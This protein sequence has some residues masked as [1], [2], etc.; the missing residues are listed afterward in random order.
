MVIAPTTINS[1]GCNESRFSCDNEYE[2]NSM[3]ISLSNG[4]ESSSYEIRRFANDSV[5]VSR[6]FENGTHGCWVGLKNGFEIEKSR[7]T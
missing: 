3:P 5:G 2:T 4:S 7:L 1:T 6:R